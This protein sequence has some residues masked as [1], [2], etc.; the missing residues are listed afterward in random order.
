MFYKQN[1]PFLSESV[2]L[3]QRFKDWLSFEKLWPLK[4]AH[5]LNTTVQLKPSAN[6]GTPKSDKIESFKTC[7]PHFFHGSNVH[8]QPPLRPAS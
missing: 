3:Y 2:L 7:G 8:P 4:L 6:G 1:V 5:F